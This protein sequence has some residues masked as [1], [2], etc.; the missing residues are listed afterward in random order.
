MHTEYLTRSEP[1]PEPEPTTDRTRATPA[2]TTTT[3][4]EDPR[5]ATDRA[6]R[7]FSYQNRARLENLVDEWNA[8]FAP[9]TTDEAA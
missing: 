7:M 3:P 4:L 8:A 2:S 9:G 1:D 6:P 5:T